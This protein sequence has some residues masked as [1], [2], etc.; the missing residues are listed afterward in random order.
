MVKIL[1]VGDFHGKLSE[2]LFNKIAKIKPDYILSP[3]DF[4]GNEKLGKLFFKYV[5]GKSEDEVPY[6]I[7]KEVV[8]LEGQA[9]RSGVGMIETLKRLKIPTFAIRGNW[10]PTPLG[11]DLV[12]KLKREE[13]VEVRKFERVQNKLFTFVDLFQKEFPEF[14]LIGGASST[15][16]SGLKMDSLERRLV[17]NGFSEEEAK[18]YVIS[19]K[20]NWKF[21]QKL[22]EKIF[23]KAISIKKRTGKKIIFLTHNAPYKTRLDLIR[24][25][26]QKGKHYGSFQEQLLIKKYQPDIVICGHMHENFGKDK[27][28]KSIIYNSGSAM[29]G[30]FITLNI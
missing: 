22:Y 18:E 10:D 30:K 28:G 9:F 15:S 11:H 7:K 1:A 20:K 12:G 13:L 25:G 3:G 5:Y 23:E 26:P 27:I 17:K 19:L 8:K 16:P 14:I 4:C 6:K 29:D 2:K 24:H 21:R